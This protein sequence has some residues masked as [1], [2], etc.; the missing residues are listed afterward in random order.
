MIDVPATFDKYQQF[1]NEAYVVDYTNHPTDE[2]TALEL[3]PEAPSV[4]VKHEGRQVPMPYFALVKH[5][6]SRDCEAQYI[7]RLCLLW[8]E[9]RGEPCFV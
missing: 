1:V 3:L 6:T 7:T 9:L 8:R 2:H 4:V 5:N